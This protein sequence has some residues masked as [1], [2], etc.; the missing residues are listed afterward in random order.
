MADDLIGA[1]LPLFPDNLLP[2][3]QTRKWPDLHTF[4]QQPERLPAFVRASPTVMR[5]LK[6]LS[7][8][9]WANFPERN[10]ER[11]WGQ[12][13]IPFAALA[14][15]E[16]I[17]LNDSRTAWTDLHGY[18]VEHPGFIWRL[19]FSLVPAP[20]DPLGFNAQARGLEQL[21]FDYAEAAASGSQSVINPKVD[22]ALWNGA[23]PPG[24]GGGGLALAQALRE[25]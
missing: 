11:H 17:K 16:L 13:Q 24:S 12:S 14:A 9:D 10:L 8:L 19:G 18:L 25:A 21:M 22:Y 20:N 6:L 2:P 15:A 7:P 23:R 4:W 5:N 3:K 1:Q